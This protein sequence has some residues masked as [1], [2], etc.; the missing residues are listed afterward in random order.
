MESNNQVKKQNNNTNQLVSYLLVMFLVLYVAMAAHKV[1]KVVIN[2]FNNTLFRLGYVLIM[3]YLYSKD[4]SVA[5]IG[6]VA[7]LVTIQSLSS[8]EAAEKTVKA[9]K[10]NESVD[11]SNGVVEVDGSVAS[12]D[13]ANGHAANGHAAN[14]HV[15]NG[16]VANGHVANG[17]V[18]N[19]GMINEGVANGGVAN[20]GVANGGVANGC[21]ANGG[22]A[23]GGVVKLS[24]VNEELV[25]SCAKK[26]QVHKEAANKANQE[27]NKELANIHMNESVKEEVKIDGIIKGEKFAI[28]AKEAEQNGDIALAEANNNEA[29]KQEVKVDAL[30]K[31]STLIESA[32]KA[33]KQGDKVK[34]KKFVE[35][36][37]KEELVAEALVKSEAHKKAAVEFEEQGDINS[38]IAHNEAAVLQES[39]VE[40][41][42]K[43]KAQ[44]QTQMKV[45]KAE[46]DVKLVKSN[47]VQKEDYLEKT[48]KVVD[49]TKTKINNVKQQNVV[50][51]S[52]CDETFNYAGYDNQDIYAA[53]NYLN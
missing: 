9:L 25:K 42:V 4:P 11:D 49:D 30:V 36:A 24:P 1:P 17:D 3:I 32:I 38:A 28:A 10:E 2:I 16:H 34:A 46:S 47:I 19:E 35:E 31:A 20:G 43:A 40:P 51:S 15:A 22:V 14:G 37:S 44:A 26:S 5:I 8:Y 12:G 27:G 13:A 48:L 6:M 39:K 33:E 23:N 41:L 29:I 52:K 50:E 45:A 7:F 18:V 21:V 53:V